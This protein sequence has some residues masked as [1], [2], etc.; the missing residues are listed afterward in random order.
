[1]V[2]TE[3]QLKT[4]FNH[5]AI[6]YGIE[7]LVNDYKIK[8]QQLDVK[9][10]YLKKQK[11]LDFKSQYKIFSLLK[12]AKPQV[13]ILHSTQTIFSC[14][15]YCYLYPKCKLIVVEHQANQLKNPKLWLLSKLAL[16]MANVNVYLTEKYKDEVEKKFPSITKNKNY[17]VIPNGINFNVFYPNSTTKQFSY[18]LGMAS[19]LTPNKDHLT[20]L[21]AIDT[22][23]TK[24][25]FSQLKLYIAG[26]GTEMPNIKQKIKQLHLQNNVVLLGMLPEKELAN[27]YR[28]LDIYVHASF[29]ETM[30]TSIM[31]AQATALPIIAS[32]VKGINNVITHQVNG[33]LYDSQNVNN[34]ANKINDLLCQKTLRLKLSKQSHNYAQQNLSA[35]NMWQAYTTLFEP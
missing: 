28:K 8:C 26:N 27:F 6:F 1:M 25:Y 16:K 24:P 19:R 21:K 14:K 12:K 31:Q 30:S 4:N 2:E 3:K 20:L 5:Q 22:L 15:A 10:N 13:I 34:L 29:G 18:C 17:I 32:N 33:L 9:Y 23:K 7:P 11:G 35:L